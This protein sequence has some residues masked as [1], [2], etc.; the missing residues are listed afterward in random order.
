MSWKLE[1]LYSGFDSPEFKKD[2]SLLEAA[3]ME[4]MNFKIKKGHTDAFIKRY[5]LFFGMFNRLMTYSNLRHMTS[6]NEK[7]PIDSLC[8]FRNMI[9]EVNQKLNSV[10]FDIKNSNIKLNIQSKYQ[11]ALKPSMDEFRNMYSSSM[12]KLKS[13]SKAEYRSIAETCA[14]SL[15]GIKS[16][17]IRL[18]ELEGHESLLGKA[19][20]LYQIPSDA[21]E[22]M[23][24]CTEKLLPQFQHFFK[25]RAKLIYR[26][27]LD[28]SE[29]YK[30]AGL[31]H[32]GAEDSQSVVSSSLKR[33]SKDAC[34]LA[35]KAFDSGWIDMHS[36]IDDPLCVNIPSIG[37]FRIKLQYE[38]TLKSTI[39]IAHELG[40][41]FHGNCLFGDSILNFSYP[42]SI[43]E[44]SALFFEDLV[45]E[46]LFAD[47]RFKESD[48]YLKSSYLTNMALFLVDVYARYLFELELV[49]VLKH[50]VPSADDLNCLMKTAL[51]TAYGESV[52]PDTLNGYL[53][54]KKSHFYNAGRPF[55]NIPY[56]FGVFIEKLLFREYRLSDS[57]SE[58]YRKYRRF[59]SNTNKTEIKDNLIDSFG[60]DLSSRST[61]RS[62]YEIIKKEVESF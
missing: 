26:S 21:F 41:G 62:G 44:T 15:S 19:L 12:S 7:D 45:Y 2:R 38:G 24:E 36:R 37:E 17:S 25:K 54:I 4:L 11:S 29:I 51:K 22:H 30:P 39:S 8:F 5:E 32:I 27:Q 57:K 55:Y 53:W 52:D 42:I 9:N 20:E 46:N 18:A 47:S 50:R 3:Y 33:F 35:E 49:K 61:W 43:G 58:F 16:T 34:E 31:G 28:Y 40:H 48:A 56:I 14:H 6:P 60:I 1:S 13:D 23:I 59:F 10:D